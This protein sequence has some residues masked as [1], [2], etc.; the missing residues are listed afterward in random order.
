MNHTR[1]SLPNGYADGVAAKPKISILLCLVLVLSGGLF[2]VRANDAVVNASSAQLIDEFK[3]SGV[4][5]R[6]F[7][8]A[9]NIVTLGDTN[10]LPELTSCLTNDDRHVRGNAAFIFAR[11]GDDRGFEVIREILADRSERSNGQGA[12]GGDWDR[13]PGR[14]WSSA[15]SSPDCLRPVTMPF[16]CLATSSDP[17]RRFPCSCRCFATKKSMTSFPGR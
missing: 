7:E 9:S 5:W 1:F 16:I 8:I 10:V 14:Q 12:P 2:V 4:F 11:L 13:R 17:R 3:K 6:Q 15:P